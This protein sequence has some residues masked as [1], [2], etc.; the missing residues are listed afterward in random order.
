MIS[1]NLLHERFYYSKTSKGLFFGIDGTGMLYKISLKNNKIHT[2]RVD[3]TFFGGN[4]FNA[5]YFTHHDSIYSYGG[6]G[7]WK[8]NGLL[9]K[10]DHTLGEWEAIM[11][12]IEI[13]SQFSAPGQTYSWSDEKENKLWLYKRDIHDIF[14]GDKGTIIPSIYC[15]DLKTKKWSEFDN[16]LDTGHLFLFH[17][18][19]GVLRVNGL[20]G[21]SDFWDFRNNKVLIADPSTSAQLRRL[22]KGANPN[23]GFTVDNWIIFGN[24]EGNT[25]DSIY[26]DLSKF[27]ESE[28]KIYKAR[29]KTI[30]SIIYDY[31]LVL[32]LPILSLAIG[33]ILI[34]KRKKQKRVKLDVFKKQEEPAEVK[35]TQSIGTPFTEL[36]LS[37]IRTIHHLSIQKGFISIDEINKILGLSN[38]NLA[39]QKK[40]RNEAINRINTKWGVYQNTK[41]LLIEKKRASFDKRNFEYFIPEK[42]MTDKIVRGLFS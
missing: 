42:L 20:H 36:E 39:V 38:K 9:R 30:M 25:L 40:N 16:V 7:F 23:L 13:T 21:E 41:E 14:N 26:L 18:E 6:Y 22:F 19:N 15:L 24:D 11:T 34:L 37:L 5:S 29:S 28:K 3:S 35:S 10:F 17:H 32:V 2:E 1:I 31:N 12:D 4:S 27:T 8:T 33:V